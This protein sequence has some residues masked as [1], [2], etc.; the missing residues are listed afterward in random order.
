MFYVCTI[1]GDEE[2]FVSFLVIKGAKKEER[3]TRGIGGWDNHS[4]PYQLTFSAIS[5]FS[6]IKWQQK[7]L[8]NE[9]VGNRDGNL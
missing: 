1:I 4:P 5:S 9:G 2:S 7:G 8:K 6:A 3:G